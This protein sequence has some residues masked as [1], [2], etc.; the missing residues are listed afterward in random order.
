M[1]TTPYNPI[2]MMTLAALAANAAEERPSGETQERREKRMM[3]GINAQLG[4]HDI[5]WTVVWAGLGKDG[6]NFA[7]IASNATTGELAVVVR[8]TIFT[9]LDLLEDLEVGALVQFTPVPITLL[10]QPLLVSEGAMKAFTE[11]TSMVSV[12][13]GTTLL[14]ELVDLV[15]STTPAIYV[16]GH[17]LGGCIASMVALWLAVG[18]DFGST[19]PS[20]IAYTF[21]APTAGLAP[22]AACYDQYVTHGSNNASWRVYNA[23]DVVP[24]AWQTLSSVESFYPSPGPTANDTVSGLISQIAQSANDNSYTQTNQTGTSMELNSD[25]STCDLAHVCET[26]ND[27]LAQAAFQHANNTYLGLLGGPLMLPLGPSVTGIAPNNMVIGQDTIVEITGNN[28][29][30]NCEVDFGTVASPSVTRVS[31]S[32]LQ[33]TA[34]NGVGVCD[35]RVT[36]IFGTSPVTPADQFAWLPTVTPLPPTLAPVGPFLTT[37]LLP[38]GGPT[39]GNTLVTINGTGFVTGC[40]VNFGSTPATQ[41]TVV[42]LTQ[43]T[44]VAPTAASA[45]SVQVTV[46][47]PSGQTSTCADPSQSA[48]AY[49]APVVSKLAP[50]CAPLNVAAK[51]LPQVTITGIGLSGTV[52]VT[53]GGKAATVQPGGS[54]IEI[55]VQPPSFDSVHQLEVPVVVTVN[56]V[57]SGETAACMFTYTSTL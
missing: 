5:G 10:N 27:F 7:Y 53:F 54:D 30:V 48:Y 46:I 42:S 8:G 32:V 24:N 47:N 23:Y 25:Y 52:S 9:P 37:A 2:P 1:P 55:S 57:P 4:Q 45:S 40:T 49:G 44:A 56:N 38:N 20:V 26:V 15:G 3:A 33:A 12:A 19:P 17:S 51:K 18:G 21:A 29:P 31:A 6:A 13:K 11:V 39:E 16:T 43:M 34:P 36:T 41:V 22:F 14:E 28:F 35:V 50:C